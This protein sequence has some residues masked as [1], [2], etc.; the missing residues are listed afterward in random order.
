[1]SEKKNNKANEQKDNGLFVFSPSE[2]EDI[3]VLHDNPSD[4]FDFIIPLDFPDNEDTGLDELK[5]EED[6]SHD[7]VVDGGIMTDTSSQSAETEK[8]N[9]VKKEKKVKKPKK[10]AVS[11]KNKK[12]NDTV[13]PDKKQDK[14]VS[15]N[16]IEHKPQKTKPVAKIQDK[17]KKELSTAEFILVISAKLILICAVVAVLIAAVYSLT[18]PIIA[19]NESAKKEAALA[20][21]FPDMVSYEIIPSN[22]AQLIN[23]LYLVKDD[24]SILGYCADVSPKGYGGEV[25]LMVGIDNERCIRCIKVL[26]HS[27]SPGYGTRILNSDY[28]ENTSGYIGFSGETAVPGKDVVDTKSGATRSSKALNNGVNS[29]LAAYSEYVIPYIGNDAFVQAESEPTATDNSDTK[30]ALAVESA[31][32]WLTDE[33]RLVKAATTKHPFDEIYAVKVTDASGVEANAGYAAIINLGNE[34]SSAKLLVTTFFR[35]INGV[36]IIEAEGDAYEALAENE[37]LLKSI[38]TAANGGVTF[39]SEN[40]EAVILYEKTLE[41]LAFYP[42]YLET[43]DKNVGGAVN[44]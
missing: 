43:I 33:Y 7:S 31:Y 3:E 34:N 28:I 39:E 6:I 14:K 19:K 2:D 13:E 23:A 38:K 4:D 1:M 27:E 16:T 42:T 44:E 32:D 18:A 21:I 26:S 41:A 29:A 15:E 11:Q 5:N 30:E 12:N 20:E 17:K 40:E 36:R 9:E 35:M 24:S 37:E 22:G 8:D 25:N 10:E